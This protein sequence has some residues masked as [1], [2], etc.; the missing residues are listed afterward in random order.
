[1]LPRVRLSPALSVK[2]D[3]KAKLRLLPLPH[4]QHTHGCASV[5][6]G[7]RAHFA[8]CPC[9]VWAVHSVLP[10]LASLTRLSDWNANLRAFI[11]PSRLLRHVLSSD[12]ENAP[13]GGGDSA[14][15]HPELG[16]EG[17]RLGSSAVPRTRFALRPESSAPLCSVGLLAS[18]WRAVYIPPTAY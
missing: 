12:A 15:V 17:A 2:C 3:H 10:S 18:A 9:L 7:P 11:L 13:G 5:T 6:L 1:M 16:L 8:F 14:L 4:L